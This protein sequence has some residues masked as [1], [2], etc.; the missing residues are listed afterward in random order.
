MQIFLVNLG[1]FSISK[2]FSYTQE[3][4]HSRLRKEQFL[5]NYNNALQADIKKRASL[6]P[7]LSRS[8]EEPGPVQATS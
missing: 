6:F 4:F 2:H 3:P 5:K 7:R 8:E 1:F